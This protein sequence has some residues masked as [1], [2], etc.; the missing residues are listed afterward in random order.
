M[1]TE[2]GAR[3]AAPASAHIPQF[4]RSFLGPR[5]WPAWLALGLLWTLAWMPWQLRSGLARVL[6]GI[7]LAGARKRR[8]IARVN[9][10][11]CF[12]QLDEAARERLL[13]QHFY[14]RLRSVLDYGVLWWGS[15]RRIG[16]LIHTRGEDHLRLPYEAGRPV[17]LLT[18]HSLMLDF[19]AAHLVLRYR[20]IGVV[21]PARNALVDWMMQRGRRR[22][23][24]TLYA[25]GRGLRDVIAGLRAGAFLYYLPDEDQGDRRATF[26]PFFGVPA[27]TLT[28]LSRLVRITDAVVVP[29]YTRYVAG[30][31]RYE[32]TLLPA[33]DNFPSGD[34]QRDAARMNQVIEQLIALA[35]EQYMW[36]MR[37]FRTRPDGGSNPYD[38]AGV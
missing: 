13:R 5:C 19:G 33:L 32:Q 15:A 7:A 21:K 8:E 29:A 27:A 11:L 20:G 4:R 34:L 24:S 37:R 18:C 14:Y 22:F 9:L 36:T 23:L 25:R 38:Q 2:S 28:A 16:K 31:G 10:K 6:T 17:I 26:A 12:P 3:Q 30:T 1:P 35:P